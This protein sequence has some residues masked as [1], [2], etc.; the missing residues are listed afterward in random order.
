MV[1]RS[2]SCPS[3]GRARGH[4]GGSERRAHGIT[5]WHRA[6]W[7]GGQ[8]SRASRPLDRR[9]WSRYVAPVGF[10]GAIDGR[11]ARWVGGGHSRASGPFDEVWGVAPVRVVFSCLAS[12]PFDSEGR[13][14]TVL[15]GAG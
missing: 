13:G 1:G 8:W 7:M 12:C 10:E 5:V 15:A 2:A 3:D 9:A 6:I 14:A 4:S 11:C